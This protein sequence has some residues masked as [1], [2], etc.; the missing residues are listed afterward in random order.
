MGTIDTCR[1]QATTN[2]A[3]CCQFSWLLYLKI[4]WNISKQYLIREAEYELF[5]KIDPWK[6]NKNM[7]CWPFTDQSMY[8]NALNVTPHSHCAIPRDRFNKFD[9][10][11]HHLHTSS[12]NRKLTGIRDRVPHSPH[13]PSPCALASSDQQTPP[14][15]NLH[16]IQSP[17]SSQHW[18]TC[19][20]GLS[21]RISP[22]PHLEIRKS[23]TAAVTDCPT[24]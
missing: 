24:F 23:L 18:Q 6:R 8:M 16:N 10:S 12:D 22:H 3:L 14:F 19:D 15:V 1:S 11:L 13:V 7:A 5:F 4:E 9:I 17:Q 21:R 20:S 2:D